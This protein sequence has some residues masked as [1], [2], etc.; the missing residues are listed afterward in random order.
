MEEIRLRNKTIFS[1]RD[2]FFSEMEV[3]APYRV[4]FEYLGHALNSMRNWPAEKKFV[5]AINAYLASDSMIR[6]DR[7]Q[8]ENSVSLSLFWSFFIS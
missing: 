6:F 4:E 2:T 5:T 3:T 7:L 1:P 8:S